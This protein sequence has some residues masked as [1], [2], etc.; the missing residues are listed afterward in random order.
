MPGATRQ[1]GCMLNS[2]GGLARQAH[3]L[4]RAPV[5]LAFF[6]HGVGKYPVAEFAAEVGLPVLE[7]RDRLVFYKPKI[8]LAIW[9]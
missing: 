2:T 9:K 5:A 6:A 3:W 8:V 1:G 7:Q 4:L